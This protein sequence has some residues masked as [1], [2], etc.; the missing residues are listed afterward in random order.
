M[1]TTVFS[2]SAAAIAVLAL[3]SPGFPPQNVDAHDGGVW[4]TKQ[5]TGQVARFIRQIGEI[6]TG[7]PANTK[8]FDIHQVA[9]QVVVHD[10]ETGQLLIVDPTGASTPVQV[11]L[12]PAV[13]QVAVNGPE[14]A[15]TLAARDRSGRVWAMPASQAVTLKVGSDDPGD[16]TPP[17]YEAGVGAELAVDVEG[18]VHV[19]APARGVVASWLPGQDVDEADLPEGWPTGS[20]EGEQSNLQVATV[21][22]DVIALDVAGGRLL[23]PFGLRTVP[24]DSSAVLQQSGGA[25]DVVLVATSSGLVGYPLDGGVS[26]DLV[27]GLAGARPVAPIRVGECYYGAFVTGAT[28]ERVRGCRQLDN[29]ENPDRDPLTSQG[30]PAT[31]TGD[32]VFRANRGVVALN[33][34]ET[35]AVFDVAADDPERI[36]WREPQITDDQTNDSDGS[37][38]DPEACKSE[39]ANRPPKAVDDPKEGRIGARSGQ[40]VVV[41]VLANDSDP[42]C[43]V[44]AVTGWDPVPE[45]TGQ[46]SLVGDG[47]LLQF[48]SD[49]EFAGRVLITYRI[50]D[51]VPGNPEASA[52]VTINVIG[53]NDPNDAPVQDKVTTL[54]VGQGKSVTYNVL[55]DFRD[56]NGDPLRLQSVDAGGA[57]TVRFTPDGQV[58]YTDGGQTEGSLTVGLMVSD[59]LDTAQG[60][61]LVQVVG[62][63][64]PPLARDDYARAVVGRQVELLPLSNDSDPNGNPLKLAGVQQEPD[65]PNLEVKKDEA[66]GRLTITAPEPGIYRLTYTVTAGARSAVGRIRVDVAA[67]DDNRPPAAMVDVAS[68]RTSETTTVD[69]LAN[70]VD[71]DDDVIAVTEHTVND[72]LILQLD[73]QRYLKITPRKRVSSPI[74]L[75]YTLTDGRAGHDVV[76]TVV[77]R[78][79]D[80]ASSGQPPIAIPDVARVRAGGAVSIPVLD[81]DLS[82]DNSRIQL[83]PE[84]ATR[85]GKGDALASGST[86]RYRAGTAGGVDRFSYEVRD[87]NDRRATGQVTVTILDPDQ[88]SAPVP[89][90]VEARV[91]QGKSVDVELPLAGTDPDGD[92]VVLKSAGAFGTLLRNQTEVLPGSSTIRYVASE[93]GTGTDLV[94]FTVCDVVAQR[95]C[96]DGIL[97][98]GVFAPPRTNRSPSAAD[99]EVLVRPGARV[100]VPVLD[101]DSDPDDDPIGFGDPALGA[102]PAGVSAEVDGRAVI[103]TAPKTPGNYRITYLI[104]DRE[105]APSVKGL[106][107]LK[108]SQYAPNQPPIARDDQAVITKAGQSTIDVDVLANDS[109]PDG[110]PDSLAITVP[111]GQSA[112]PSGR[113]VRVTLTDAPRVVAYVITDGDD[114]RA[115]GF[116]AVP[117]LTPNLPPKASGKSFEVP[118]GEILTLRVEDFAVDPE[119]DPLVIDNARG[120]AAS[121]ASM[122]ELVAG[123]G[124]DVTYQPPRETLAEEAR[125]TIPVRA[126]AGYTDVVNIPIVVKITSGENRPP[127]TTE[128]EFQVEQAST[129]SV[130][131]SLLGAVTDPDPE[132]KG[133]PFAFSPATPAQGSVTGVTAQLAPD[134]RLTLDADETTKVG[135]SATFTYTVSDARGKASASATFRVVVVQTT[136]EPPRALADDLPRLD[137]GETVRVDVLG[138]DVD[139]FEGTGRDPISIIDVAASGA[140]TAV[141][142]ADARAITVTGGAAPG[143]AQVRYTFVDAV[144]R[145]AE[146]LLTVTVWGP[147]SPVATA[148]KVD[149][150]TADTVTLSWP[151]SSANAK[152]EDPKAKALWY[153]VSWSS[154]GGRAGSQRCEA[155]TCTIVDLKPGATYDFTVTAENVVGKADP[156]PVLRGVIPDQLPAWEQASG[157]QFKVTGFEDGRLSLGWAAPQYPGSPLTGYQFSVTPQTGGSLP[158]LDGRTT[159]ITVPGLTNGVGYTF[160]LC[161]ENRVGINVDQCTQTAGTAY[162]PPSGLG[163][164]SIQ[165]IADPVTSRVTASWPLPTE[166]GGDAGALS[167]DVTLLRDGA[168]VSGW[169]KDN[170]TSRQIDVAVEKGGGEYSVR[171]AVLNPWT[172]LPGNTSPS[173]TSDVVV[174]YDAP[175]AVVGLSAQGTGTDRQLRV[176]FS[177]PANVGPKPAAA[178]PS[179]TYWYRVGSGSAQQMSTSGTSPI[180]SL[181]SVP[182]NGSN[183]IEVWAQ[184]NLSG[185]RTTRTAVAFGPPLAPLI[186]SVTKDSKV[187]YTFCY[188]ASSSDNG[189]GVSR[190]QIRKLVNGGVVLGWTDAAYP[191]GCYQVSGGYSQT[192]EL[193]VRAYDR[194]G[195]AGA[196]ASASRVT[197]P[198]PAVWVRKGSRPSSGCSNA[199][200]AFIVVELDNLSPNTNYSVTLT[201]QQGNWDGFSG[202]VTVRSDG[203][204]NAYQ[205]TSYFWGYPGQWVQADVAGTGLSHRLTW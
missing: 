90:V 150:L 39:G 132:D 31:V 188:N 27:S 3:S 167:Y 69:L 34:V 52:Q 163:T 25:A 114:G 166:V 47:R 147:P 32:L 18:R 24:Q 76:G 165:L 127:Q 87:A 176:T 30:K 200:C 33:D 81:N 103:V 148:P 28:G 136:Q 67:A 36:D 189:N 137:Q 113:Q 171:V 197:D 186:T 93:P 115:M 23:L 179:V 117:A 44:L 55:P 78:A 20:R 112:D 144:G 180:T 46:V 107:D 53:V 202:V 204:G 89:P 183:T 61:L 128:L 65:Q 134:G 129:E 51:G 16:D 63:D 73:R 38:S 130:V 139:P 138:N 86:L 91:F 74:L 105:D 158:M 160:T 14:G 92:L 110:T 72:A 49:A 157:A 184:N 29:L 96:A 13:D 123:E 97:K 155:S 142:T 77:V 60:K 4:V 156:S 88:N 45:T 125:L 153:T 66:A 17:S 177:P 121:P 120:A 170:G 190:V 185:V 94:R 98:V 104:R 99:D 111:P 135:N 37:T 64:A 196:V 164:P 80:G 159:S 54:S 193:Q 19:V 187:D 85:P 194:D 198:P 41:A 154:V 199:S 162:G 71:P 21:G 133:G 124:T 205:Q 83:V 82:P 9:G 151:P 22:D 42:D 149:A 169:P 56:P 203:A 59:G 50:S 6:D 122:R 191:T 11:P 108:V 126:T 7:Q 43:D 1:S 145:E 48:Q 119:G 100:A 168:P 143:L 58:T 79:D 57:G 40:P 102:L 70:D 109:D 192:L 75:T 141:A 8:D 118:A 2:V 95:L 131:A 175:S 172:E 12:P 201:N 26:R 35:G 161:P 140:V 101:N 152:V 195:L 15:A 10:R 178:G 68:V 116:I 174:S 181:V 173:V 84:L 5:P 62:T 182:A 146:G 106:I